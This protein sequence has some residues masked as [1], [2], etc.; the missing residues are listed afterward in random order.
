LQ[1]NFSFNVKSCVKNKINKMVCL[2]QAKYLFGGVFL[3]YFYK[4]FLLGNTIGWSM[5][6]TLPYESCNY[7]SIKYGLKRGDIVIVTKHAWRPIV[8]IC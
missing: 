2:N 4:Y 6:P 8:G 7:L 3:I 5:Y 1:Y